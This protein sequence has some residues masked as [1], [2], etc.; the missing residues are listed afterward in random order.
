[1]GQQVSRTCGGATPEEIEAKI[2]KELSDRDNQLQS[3]SKAL[4]AAK[5]EVDRQREESA[6]ERSHLIQS[7]TEIETQLA[8]ERERCSALEHE[9]TVRAEES[10]RRGDELD[11]RCFEVEELYKKAVQDLGTVQASLQSTQTEM[12]EYQQRY[13]EE[14]RKAE[15]LEMQVGHWMATAQDREHD[16]EDLQKSIE[17]KQKASQFQV[18]ATHELE[19]KLAAEK[20]VNEQ[21]IEKYEHDVEEMRDQMQVM[22]DEITRLRSELDAANETIQSLEARAATDSVKQQAQDGKRAPASLSFVNVPPPSGNLDDVPDNVSESMAES[23]ADG[24]E[25]PPVQLSGARVPSADVWDRERDASLKFCQDQARDIMDLINKGQIDPENAQQVQEFTVRL[26]QDY[27]LKHRQLFLD[28]WNKYDLDHDGLLSRD[29]CR[30]LVKDSLSASRRVM[31]SQI[32]DA[33]VSMLLLSSQEELDDEARDAIK[34]RVSGLPITQIVEDQASKL[35]VR[36]DELADQLWERLD[37]DQDG[38]VTRDDFLEGY[39]E[40][41]NEILT[42]NKEIVNAILQGVNA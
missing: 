16:F 2:K 13:E 18:S 27:T 24:N 15:D 20:R 28:I 40:A 41:S 6:N 12:L 9:S 7:T 17:S 19:L 36:S 33:I 14:R 26:H 4:E 38:R 35:I 11:K 34:Q 31:P 3:L 1:M 30:G 8:Q 37:K 22:D 25:V 29:E 23:K 5:Q 21:L 32:I 10:A 42:A 39:A